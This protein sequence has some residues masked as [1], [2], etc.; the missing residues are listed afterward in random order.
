M[1]FLDN[2]F[3]LTTDTAQRL[4][5]E[6][7]A[8][9]PLYDYHCHL[10]PGD[11]ANNRVYQNLLRSGWRVIIT[12]G[13][14]M[15]AN[16]IDED[17]ITGNAD[18]YDKYLAWAKTV[19][20]TLR[21]PL[22]Q[23]SHLELQRYFGINTLLDES[24]AKEI[25]DESERQLRSLDTHT[26][27]DR[28][29]VALVCTTDDPLDSLEHHVTIRSLGIDTKVYPAFRPD[30]IFPTGELT[31]WNQ[32]VDQIASVAQT[33]CS[34]L[35]SLVAIIG[36]HHDRFHESGSRLSDHAF[37]C[38]PDVS[39]TEAEATTA[40]DKARSHAI[41]SQVERDQL[42][43]YLLQL[44]ARL[45]A[46]RDWTKQ[47]HLGPIRNVNKRLFGLLGRDIGCDSIGDFQQGPGLARFL[48]ELDE[49]DDLSRL[50]LYNNNPT[51]NYLFATMIGN[52]QR[53]PTAGKL[54]WGSGWWHLDQKDG[55]RWQINALSNLGL[56]PRF[57]GM[58][59]DSRSMMSYPRHEYFRRVL[60][61]LMGEDVAAGELPDD[62]ELLSKL[63]RGICFHNAAE[64]FQL[65]LAP[66]YSNLSGAA[67]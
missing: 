36:Y 30:R 35:A 27:L 28:F 53:G 59:T 1:G 43:I 32:Y 26:I 54:Q 45:D 61:Q 37:G 48:G 44:T 42:T 67:N 22:Y 33:Q 65:E 15:R 60:C 6:V 39:P 17:F 19:P 49:T 11:I 57:V 55:M 2:D 4:Y 34:D 31:A 51:D 63:V 10:L 64:Y 46:K 12:N 50:I 7:A 13:R 21:N 56:L 29:N 62:I 16:G 38:L 20:R 14:A 8:G 40:F 23:W 41:L 18:P 66:K 3:L 9:L 52:F 25:W 47:L 5:H 24:T 58:L